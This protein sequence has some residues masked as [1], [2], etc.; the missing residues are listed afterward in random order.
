LRRIA[1]IIAA[2]L[3]LSLLA[4]LLVLIAV[5]I[6]FLAPGNPFYRSW[7][8]GRGGK[9]F[10]MWKFRT[11]VP[12]AARIGPLIT[13]KNDSR[14]TAFGRLLRKT[15]VDEVPQFLNVLLGDMT[16]VGPRP[17]VPEIVDLYDVQQRAV[18]SVK[19]GITG[20]VQLRW[21]DESEAIPEG[22]RG[23]RYYLD[24]LM[25]CK[26]RVDLEYLRART[27][28]T[29]AQVLW[30]TAALFLRRLIANPLRQRPPRDTSAA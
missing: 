2:L 10:R 17:E 16:L 6:I 27:S 22:D 18:L 1:D 12:N 14:I 20:P 28:L 30:D 24:H 21:A 5:A 13:V 7:R 9:R 19:P 4:P 3:V 11:M 29:D 25:D 23:I 8:I 26:I 15:K